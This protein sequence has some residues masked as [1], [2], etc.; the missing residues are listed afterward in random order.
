MPNIVKVILLAVGVILVGVLSGAFIFLLVNQKELSSKKKNLFS[1]NVTQKEIIQ[2]QKKE[3]CW[4]KKGNSLY[5]SR[6]LDASS[7]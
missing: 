7:P 1:G 6:I 4:K 5:S 3:K 2:E